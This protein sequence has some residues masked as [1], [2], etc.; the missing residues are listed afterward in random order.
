M[1]TRDNGEPLT[2]NS[3]KW[4]FWR[5]TRAAGLPEIRFHDLRHSFASQL[6]SAGRPLREVQEL[7]GHQSMQVTLRY[8]HLAPER[9]RDAIDVLDVPE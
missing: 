1:F 8:A 2:R 5:H 3:I 4:A 6:V 7:L 9:M